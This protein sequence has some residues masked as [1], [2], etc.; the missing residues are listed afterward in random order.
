[1]GQDASSHTTEVGQ[2]HKLGLLSPL[3]E[4]MFQHVS[5]R[6]GGGAEKGPGG[7]GGGAPAGLGPM[8]TQG[9]KSL[10][11]RLCAPPQGEDFV[12]REM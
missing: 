3:P 8:L 5:T 1:M 6:L 11:P 10:W 7:A 12:C 4:P 2:W 9:K